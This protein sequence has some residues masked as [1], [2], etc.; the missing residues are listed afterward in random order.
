MVSV[1]LML[2]A[3]IKS[4]HMLFVD[5]GAGIALLKVEQLYH[6]QASKLDLQTSA[7]S[8]KLSYQINSM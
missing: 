6:R 3:I 7:R 2:T 1:A 5:A 8:T 4:Q